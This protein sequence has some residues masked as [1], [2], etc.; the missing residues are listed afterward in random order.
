MF[1]RFTDEARSVVEGARGQALRLGDHHVGTEHLLL[2]L[3]EGDGPAA[4]LLGAEGITAEGILAERSGF[5]RRSD[6]P[7]ESD[8]DA[9]AGLGI[10]LDLVRNVV[11]SKFGAGALARSRAIRRHR[12]R[13]WRPGTPSCEI[14]LGSGYVPFS[15]PAKRT[16]E[17][18][19]RASLRLGQNHVGPEHVGLG[20]LSEPDGLGCAILARQ[21]VSLEAL[22]AA[23]ERAARRS[24]S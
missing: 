8:R 23:L 24:A 4:E 5:V 21:G 10:D 15:E 14:A 22:R 2:T 16:L 3:S 18:S 19:L 6:G 1:E 9:L 20:L 13:G 7:C 11:D 12:R 17:Q